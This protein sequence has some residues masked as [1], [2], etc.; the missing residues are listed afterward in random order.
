MSQ[1]QLGRG[2]LLLA[3]INRGGPGKGHHAVGEVEVGEVIP[4]RIGFRGKV[5]HHS[6]FRLRD[7]VIFIVA[8]GDLRHFYFITAWGA[9]SSG[10]FVRS[11]SFSHSSS[12]M[13]ETLASISRTRT[14]MLSKTLL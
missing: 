5:G 6:G 13:A 14:S 4:N 1:G 12:R 2:Q 8:A 9:A 7:V 3:P 11:Q 10:G